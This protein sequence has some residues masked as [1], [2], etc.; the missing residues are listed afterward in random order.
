LAIWRLDD[1]EKYAA[2]ADEH[3]LPLARLSLWIGRCCTAY[4]RAGELAAV[5]FS[6]RVTGIRAHGAKLEV[7]TAGLVG[8]VLQKPCQRGELLIAPV[9]KI[10]GMEPQMKTTAGIARARQT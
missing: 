6:C 2:I 1:T 5:G 7:A 10:G 4:A 9:I 3:N 8:G